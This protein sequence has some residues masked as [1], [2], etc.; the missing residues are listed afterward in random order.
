MS[1]SDRPTD[2]QVAIINTDG[3]FHVSACPGAGKTRTIVA[4]FLR[5]ARDL[6]RTRGTAVLSFTNSAADEIAKRCSN[7]SVRRLAGFPHFIGTFDSFIARM[8]IVPFALAGAPRAPVVLDSWER[9]QLDVRPRGGTRAACGL[10]LDELVAGR[11]GTVSLRLDR[12]PS[13][14]RTLVSR[15]PGAW[16]RAATAARGRLHGRGLLSC[17]DARSFLRDWIE[18][19]TYRESVGQVLAARFDEVV[20]DEAQ[21][22]S[23]VE[24]E[25]LTWLRESGIPVVTVCDPQQSIYGF[26]DARPDLLAGFAAGVG[27]KQLT[28]NFRSTPAICRLAATMRP[29]RRQDVPLGPHKDDRTPVLVLAHDGLDGTVGALYVARAGAHGLNDDAL[30]VLAHSHSAARRS[31]GLLAGTGVGATS[32]CVELA[33]AA[34][35]LHSTTAIPKDRLAAIEAFERQVLRWLSVPVDE[36]VPGIAADDATVTRR[37]LRR[38]ALEVAIAV[39][40]APEHLEEVGAWLDA[41]RN[42]LDAMVLPRSWRGE[43]NRATLPHKPTSRWTVSQPLT[44]GPRPMT[45]HAAKGMEFGGVLLALPHRD[46]RA[47]ALVA[48]WEVGADSEALRVAYV[49]VTRAQRLAGIAV[50]RALL[51]RVLAILNAGDVPHEVVDGAAVDATR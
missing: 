31:V 13:Q 24:I 6:P 10:S 41:L 38:V 26:R 20:V 43:V 18:D 51:E 47:A 28:G 37:W 45:V 3:A 11:D 23:E 16:S 32:Q 7:A 17:D 2:E 1:A 34:T 40:P 9:L 25:V 49:A 46:A 36:V 50:P 30:V 44:Q 8:L 22:C 14:I 15:D 39:G 42:A 29:G 4:R 5:R 12:V 19:P 35:V 27:P 21:D 48:D 33:Q